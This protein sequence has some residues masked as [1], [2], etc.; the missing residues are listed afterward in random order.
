MKRT[1]LAVALSLFAFVTV[2]GADMVEST[3]TKTTTFTGTVSE[4][5][6]SASTI[7][8]RGESS[9]TPVTYSF[10]PQTTFVDATGNTIT[11][12]KIRNSPVRVEYATEG[13]RTVARRV[14]VVNQ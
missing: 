1:A 11:V 12:D 2:A 13:G 5:N 14:V 7:I 10:T 9:P 8:L 4:V 6:P 3:T